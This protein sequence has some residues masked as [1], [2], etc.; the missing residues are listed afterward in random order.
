MDRPGILE[1]IALR[2]K[3]R[4]A[5]ELCLWADVTESEGIVGDHRGGTKRQVTILSRERWSQT[6]AELNVDLPWHTRRANLLVSGV[7]LAKAIGNQIRIGECIFDIHGEVDPCDRMDEY[8][9]GLMQALYPDTRG[10]VW[11]RVV[12]GG[13]LKLNQA[14][15]IH[16]TAKQ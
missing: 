1:S 15:S 5:M 4:A 14:V 13:C 3:S 12:R 16:D 6:I 10:G 8:H 7:D 11:G 9:D 2:R